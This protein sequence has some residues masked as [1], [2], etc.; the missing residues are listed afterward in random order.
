MQ[1][2]QFHYFIVMAF[3]KTSILLIKKKSIPNN[4]SNGLNPSG[5]LEIQQ[6][7]FSVS[8][9]FN[10]ILFGAASVGQLCAEH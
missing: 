6:L 2:N 8:Q 3:K 9:S 5:A 1:E 4:F 7:F 10:K